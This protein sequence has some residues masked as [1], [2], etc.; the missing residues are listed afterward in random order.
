[1]TEMK[2]CPVLLID[3]PQ[4]WK[5]ALYEMHPHTRAHMCLIV[6]KLPLLASLLQR[7]ETRA[8]VYL[9]CVPGLQLQLTVHVQTS[10]P[11]WSF[12]FPWCPRCLLNP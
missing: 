2:R 8:L 7:T 5:K 3:P 9:E 4:V 6:M 10:A 11:L 1:M 12:K